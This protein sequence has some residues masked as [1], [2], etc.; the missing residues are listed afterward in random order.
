VQQRNA[1]LKARNPAAAWHWD[2][3]LIA[4]GLAVDECRRRL[5]ALLQPAVQKVGERLLGAEVA[6]SYLSGWAEG[7]G[8]REALLASRDRDLQLA[9]STVGPHRADFRITVRTRRARD[10]VSRGQEK[11]VVAALTLAQVELVARSRAQTVVLLLD[12]PGADLDRGHLA[13]LLEAIADSAVQSFVT[14][15]DPTLVPL[16]KDARTFHVE[17]AGIASFAIISG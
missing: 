13:R 1:A 7:T 17:R 2:D 14:S 10:T 9:T 6:L 3:S 5:M 4:D 12:E 11:L 15:L 16:P 8:L